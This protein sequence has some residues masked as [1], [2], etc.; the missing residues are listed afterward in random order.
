M[1]DSRE[2]ESARRPLHGSLGVPRTP[3]ASRPKPFHAGLPTGTGLGKYRI[4]ERIR[5]THNAI[6]YKARDA[7]LDRLVTI[8]QMSPDLIDDPVA[9]GHFKREAQFLARIPRGNAYIVSIHELI[10][11]DLG[12]FIVEEYVPGQWL[13]SLISKRQIDLRG[14]VRILKT[15]ALGLRTLHSLGIAHRG[16]HPGN[17]L[18]ARNGKAKITNLATAAHESDNAPPPV[19]VSKYAAP[20]LLLGQCYDDRVDV[21]SLGMV[22]FEMCVGRPALNHSFADLLTKPRTAAS[23]WV[24]WHTDMHASLPSASELNPLVPPRL[25]ALVRRMTAKDLDERFASIQEILLALCPKAEDRV[26]R[27]SFVAPGLPAILMP[28]SQLPMSP[29]AP[30]PQFAAGTGLQTAP[31]PRM[32]VQRPAI[33]S[34]TYTVRL[35]KKEPSVTPARTLQPLQQMGRPGSPGFPVSRPQPRLRHPMRAGAVR[36]PPQAKT[37]PQP[38]EVTETIKERHPHLVVWVAVAALFVAAITVGGGLLWHRYYGPGVSH[39]IENVFA[40]AVQAYGEGR[41]DLAQVRLREAIRMDVRRPRFVRIRDKAELELILVQAERAFQR[42][43]FD[44]A[45]ER[46][47]EAR[48]RGANPTKIDE[49]QARIWNKKDAYRLVAQGFA[50]LDH[51]EFT[52]VELNLEEYEAKARAA[53]EDPHKLRDRLDLSRRERKYVEAIEEANVALAELDYDGAL[54]ACDDAEKLKIT[55]ETRALHK[56]IL[57][58]RERAEWIL[59]GDE[60]ML[61]KDFEAAAKAYEK[62]NQIEASKEIEAKTRLAGAYLLHDQALDAIAEG[63]LLTAERNLKSSLWKFSTPQARTKLTKMASAF[64]AARLVQKGDRAMNRNDYAGAER[65]Y[66]EALP[67]LPE[68][69]NAI[70]KEK[71]LQAHRAARPNGANKPTSAESTPSTSRYSARFPKATGSH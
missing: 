52:N 29:Q 34:S 58:L 25:A 33:R 31:V 38:K 67:H 13:E 5:T 70:V 65:L 41:L 6:V 48:R 11:D 9:C 45:E 71:I 53:G 61:S 19:I 16:I 62:A 42:D 26:G 35:A 63:D 60:A 18:V 8:K 1:A 66:A 51:G 28:D 12:L 17:I 68:P 56:R 4:L 32:S 3:P 59:R 57:N 20:E 24:D 27:I 69:A 22:M 44:L 21:Y 46:L 37:V 43:E 50:D 55:S 64:E 49:I 36:R 23:R 2:H 14:A 7:M 40:E 15:A 54:L 10:E 39:P 30:Y 47:R